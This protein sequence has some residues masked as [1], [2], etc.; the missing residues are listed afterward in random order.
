LFF[1]RWVEQHT[2]NRVW[3]ACVRMI[4]GPARLMANLALGRAPWSR[5]A[6]PLDWR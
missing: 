5:D 1:V 6:R 2:T 3:R 4:F